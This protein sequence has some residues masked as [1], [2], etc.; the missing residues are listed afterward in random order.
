[1]RIIFI[2]LLLGCCL[3]MAVAQRANYKLAEQ[4]KS[5]FSR[6]RF[7]RF[8]PFFVPESDNFWYKMDTD[9]G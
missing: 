1:M 9:D 6:A 2:C 4:A 5:D 8:V 7:D 3:N